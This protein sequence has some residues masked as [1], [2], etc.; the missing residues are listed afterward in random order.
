MSKPEKKIVQKLIGVF[1]FYAH[2]VDCTMLAALGSLAAQQANPFQTT[3][4]H[5]TQFLNYAAS[6]VMV[7]YR[8]SI[9][10]LAVHSDASYLSET[11]ARSHAGGNFFL[12]DDDIFL[13]TMDLS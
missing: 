4:Q 3:M 2:A 9:M 1:L 5:V 8:S 12:S 6:H 7:T 11:K 10:I 13:Q